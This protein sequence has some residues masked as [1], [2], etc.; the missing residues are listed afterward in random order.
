MLVPEGKSMILP[1]RKLSCLALS[2]AMC[3]FSVSVA[4]AHGSSGGSGSSGGY[5][6]S[7]GSSSGGSG[8]H[9]GPGSSASSASSGSNGGHSPSLGYS[10]G[11]NSMGGSTQ[12]GTSHGGTSHGA[13]SHG[14]ASHG[15]ASHGAFGGHGIFGGLFGGHQSHSSSKGVSLASRSH[16]VPAAV[17]AVHQAA[18]K[19]TDP[20]AQQTDPPA[21]VTQNVLTNQGASDTG[22]VHH[23]LRRSKTSQNQLTQ[24]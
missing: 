13:T 5:G 9:G 10:P 22:A 21:Q 8:S 24:R 2:C 7:S 12:G 18:T 17:P 1:I 4:M 23:R 11:T 15:A 16:T 3:C 20:P 14:A 6:S 19:R